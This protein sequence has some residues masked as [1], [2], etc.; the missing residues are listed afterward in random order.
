MDEPTMA[1]V[2]QRREPPLIEVRVNF[3]IFAGREATPAEID[4]LA[5]FLLDEVAAVSIVSE[6]RHEID[7]NGEAALHQV[8]IEIPGDGVDEEHRRR[9][10]ERVE[11][12]TRV[13]VAER[14]ADVTDGA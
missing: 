2:V 3:G 9:I 5:E 14:H 4:R 1:F 6:D 13:C 8:R 12:W 7:T 10:L 11:H